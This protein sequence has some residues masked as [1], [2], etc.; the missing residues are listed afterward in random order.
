M[1]TALLL[2]LVLLAAPTET[3]SRWR[4]DNLD[5]S[6]D[7]LCSSFGR[8]QASMRAEGRPETDYAR[9]GMERHCPGML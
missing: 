1:K 8:W 5:R 2:S 4:S 7:A 9:T 6:L 3:A